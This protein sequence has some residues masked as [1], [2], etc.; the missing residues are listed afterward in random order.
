MA[1]PLPPLFSAPHRVFFAAGA[2]QALVPLLWWATVLLGRTGILAA[3]QGLPW[4]P[5]W[6]HGVVM[7]FGVFPF[8][9]QGFLMTAGPKWRGAAPRAARQYL[10]AWGGMAG[11]W[12]LVDGGLILGVPS[13]AL[14]GLGLAALGWALATWD[15]TRLF[16]PEAG[17]REDLHRFLAANGFARQAPYEGVLV[18]AQWLGV[19][20][21]GGAVLAL[22]SQSPGGVAA[23]EALALWA[24]LLPTFFA[25]AL[26]M[27]PFFT[28]A[29]IRP[30]VPWQPAWVLKGFFAACLLHGALSG[31]R[32]SLW[33]LP[34]DFFL[35]G[36]TAYTLWRWQFWRTLGVP[37]VA[38]LHISALWLPLGFLLLGLESL[39]S[40]R[41]GPGLYLGGLH[42]LTIGYFSSLLLA[43][44]TRVSR[45]HSGRPID[46]DRVGWPLF[47]GLQLVALVRVVG[48]WS[49]PG[50]VAPWLHVAAV[51][52]W[53][54]ALLAWTVVHGEMYL[55]PRPDGL[56]G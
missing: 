44:A 9:V 25:V 24:F 13:L 5:A 56:P 53:L 51:V 16:R 35:A 15:L 22:G 37:M 39:L 47:W 52:G 40:L 10:P 36:L 11:G 38:M 43:M 19:L 23:V 8:F 21:Q 48:A 54:L 45:G 49:W 31:L 6:S 33:A 18:C 30:Y 41:G 55:K 4:P 7:L 14:F 50:L 28:G 20:A 3:A 42:G 26:R 46:G 29:V 17:E 34:L 32:L 1:H 2:V 27:V 12:L